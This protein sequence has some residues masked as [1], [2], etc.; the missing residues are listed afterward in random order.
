MLKTVMPTIK[1][2]LK[3]IILLAL[4]IVLL[5]AC[6]DENNPPGCEE[7]EKPAL[8]QTTIDVDEG[9]EI[10]IQLPSPPDENTTIEIYGPD[11]KKIQS[12]NTTIENAKPEN[13]GIYKVYFVRNYCKSQAAEVTV[14]VNPLS[15]K[16]TIP[17]DCIR[18][19]SLGRDFYYSV[20]CGKSISS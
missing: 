19:P 9:S 13:E 12:Y 5:S 16:C 18:F 6:V 11:N 2:S 1:Y 15:V 7:V 14:N 17:D 20:Y 3:Q 10:F 4:T 8:T